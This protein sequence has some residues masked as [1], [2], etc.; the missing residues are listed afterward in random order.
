MNR[1]SGPDEVRIVITG[2]PKDLENTTH[3]TIN[4][5]LPRSNTPW[6]IGNNRYAQPFP[7]TYNPPLANKFTSHITVMDNEGKVNAALEQA[8]KQ[9]PQNIAVAQKDAQSALNTATISSVKN[10]SELRSAINELHELSSVLEQALKDEE[11]ARQNL[12]EKRQRANDG[13]NRGIHLFKMENFRNKPELWDFVV[14]TMSHNRHFMVS[15]ENDV[16][17]TKYEE[18]HAANNYIMMKS[19]VTALS[20]E[21]KAKTAKLNA[22]RE[23]L[24]LA[25]TAE[26]T[27][28][29]VRQQTTTARREEAQRE[30]AQLEEKL[31]EDTK[32]LATVTSDMTKKF[33]KEFGDLATELSQN[34]RGKKIRNY[35]DAMASFAKFQANPYINMSQIDRNAIA[36]AL[37]ALDKRTL[38]DNLKRLSASSALL[39]KGF[40]AAVFYSKFEE[41]CRTDNWKPLMLEIEAM[42]L[43]GVAAAAMT[44]FLP[45]AVWLLSLAVPPTVAFIVVVI[46]IAIVASWVNAEFVD[47]L[48]GAILDY[49]NSHIMDY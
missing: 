48:N 22:I 49:I 37:K 26:S 12:N 38:A 18:F 16:V 11:S 31:K 9:Y 8:G 24:M 47:K 1:N 20:E 2:G 44:L 13:L 23:R 43:S 45:Q 14:G 5:S 27:P 36:D 33:G 21:L 3:H 30:A 15:W 28:N 25:S 41:G 35:Q 6:P 4:P 42:A 7:F 19:R 40:T 34:I 32:L 39:A 17:K 29:P 10:N 46:S